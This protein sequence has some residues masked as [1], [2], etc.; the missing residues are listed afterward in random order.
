MYLK[1]KTN[2]LQLFLGFLI[3]KKRIRQMINSQFVTKHLIFTTKIE[4]IC[5]L[6]DQM[7]NGSPD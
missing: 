2:V 6:F 1:V 3:K 7:K 5:C 4:N